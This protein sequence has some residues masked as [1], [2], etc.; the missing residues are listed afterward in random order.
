M[1]KRLRLAASAIIIALAV[2]GVATALS[3]S[4]YYVLI[5]TQSSLAFERFPG[6]DAISVRVLGGGGD[7]EVINRA[8]Y[9]FNALLMIY[10]SD[11]TRGEYY[12]R[13]VRVAPGNNVFKSSDI[14]P[15]GRTPDFSRSYMAIGS[16]LIPI[17]GGLGSREEISSGYAQQQYSI[18]S[19]KF[20]AYESGSVR[21][22]QY[23]SS[24]ALGS[25]SIN[26]E[27][28]YPRSTS[29]CDQVTRE[30]TKKEGY[31]PSDRLEGSNCIWVCCRWKYDPCC[32]RW[33][34]ECYDCWNC[35]ASE[36]DSQPY[37]VGHPSYRPVSSDY[38]DYFCTNYYY[39][40]YNDALSGIS[41]SYPYQD[42]SIALVRGAEY[43]QFDMRQNTIYG[44]RSGYSHL[45]VTGDIIPVSQTAYNWQY[46]YYW[47]VS[48]K[49]WY[50]IARPYGGCGGGGCYHDMYSDTV[51]DGYSRLLAQEIRYGCAGYNWGATE[52]DRVLSISDAGSNISYRIYPLQNGQAEIIL[53]VSVKLWINTKTDPRALSRDIWLRISS[54]I[55]LIAGTAYY[56]VSLPK[57]PS[58]PTLYGGGRIQVGIIDSYVVINGRRDSSPISI[59]Y[60]DLRQG[61]VPLSPISLAQGDIETYSGSL[62]L[63][64]AYITLSSDITIKDGASGCYQQCWQGQT[65]RWVCNTRCEWDCWD[66]GEWGWRCGYICYCDWQYVCETTTICNTICAS[67]RTHHVELFAS[68]RILVIPIAN[69][70]SSR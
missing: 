52:C 14:V 68:M 22:S 51:Y 66:W 15:P 26:V 43:G 28:G 61:Q 34:N 13:V 18:Y 40:Y 2:I 1:K 37:F 45:V 54:S 39:G 48:R 49:V 12:G 36:P 63:G 60:S 55:P 56:E 69:L 9:A 11:G 42:L 8:G 35:L 19:G 3:L 53:N 20:G 23:W 38:R 70:Q 33:N 25:S 67:S 5:N 32:W 62:S 44:S 57:L 29:Y 17:A 27:A 59:S 64:Q 31:E 58:Q 4:T 21:I 10:G 46:W 30:I 65:C 24:L 16:I 6:A 7:I 41:Y 47:V 50:H